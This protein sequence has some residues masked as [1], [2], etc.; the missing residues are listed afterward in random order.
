VSRNSRHLTSVVRLD[1]ADGNQRVAAL[2]QRFGDQV[3]EL[4]CFV[5][6]EGDARVAVLALGP[7]LGTAKVPGQPFK[8]MD[9]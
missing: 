2:G 4:A 8:R 7:Q 1:T 5:A 9:R 3:F 6:T